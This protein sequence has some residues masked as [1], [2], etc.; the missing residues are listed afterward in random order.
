M[1][2]ASLSHHCDL[3]KDGPCYHQPQQMKKFQVSLTLIG[4][5][6]GVRNTHGWTEMLQGK[7]DIRCPQKHP[8]DE[9]CSELAL[10]ILS[11]SFPSS[12]PGACHSFSIISFLYFPWYVLLLSAC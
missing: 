12:Y 3:Q 6:D 2:C 8:V 7:P 10:I 4:W 5:E 11:R 1:M 9:A